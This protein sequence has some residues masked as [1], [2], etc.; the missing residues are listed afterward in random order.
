MIRIDSLECAKNDDLIS[1]V[2]YLF[3]AKKKVSL[4]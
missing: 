3:E 1:F 4:T 2:Y